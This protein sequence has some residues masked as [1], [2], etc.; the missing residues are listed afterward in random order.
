MLLPAALYAADSSRWIQPEADTVIAEWSVDALKPSA[1]DDISSPFARA[2]ASQPTSLDE[3]FRLAGRPGGSWRFDSIA[4]HLS[5]TS[6]NDPSYT[7]QPK[8]YYEARLLQHQHHFDDAAD[9][10]NALTTSDTPAFINVRLLL[11]QIRYQQGNTDA[12]ES[13]CRSLTLHWSAGLVAT[14]LA[15]VSNNYNPSLVQLME[16]TEPATHTRQ[17]RL[18][19]NSQI[20]RQ[21]ALGG[22]HLLAWEA[23]ENERRESGLESMT[24]PDVVLWGQLAAEFLKPV[25][26]LTLLTPLVQGRYTDD[27]ILLLL[28]QASQD[29]DQRCPAS[30][31]ADWLEQLDERMRLRA[32]RNDLSYAGVLAE[33][34]LT[35]DQQP[36]MALHWAEQ[37]AAL[38]H[39]PQARSLLLRAQTQVSHSGGNS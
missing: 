6:R 38:N 34:F 25:E 37:H 31:R 30:L 11:A 32:Q 2:D 5:S 12:A 28:G 8:S 27:A 9:K 24:V 29:C 15:S 33:Y 3:T 17:L 18:W 10:L 20:A 35:I 23:L 22:E 36:D 14:C 21:Y 1:A 4:F 39:D 13:L 7:S 26:R 16:Q 19:I